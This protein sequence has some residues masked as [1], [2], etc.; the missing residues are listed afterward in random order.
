MVVSG[1]FDRRILGLGGTLVLLSLVCA[2]PAPACAECGDYVIVIR[3]TDQTTP[4]TNHTPMPTGPKCHGPECSAAP[5][6]TMSPPTTRPVER[7]GLDLAGIG[8]RPDPT[9]PGA[10]RPVVCPPLVLTDSPSD[11]FHP[12]RAV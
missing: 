5:S 6:K 7:P 12:P 2:F 8:V 3:K 11:I 1:L 9:P 10:I 4:A